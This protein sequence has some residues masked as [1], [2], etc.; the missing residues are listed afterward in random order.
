VG[1][2]AGRLSLAPIFGLSLA[3]YLNTV[4]RGEA[5]V[6]DWAGI[7]VAERSLPDNTPT[8]RVNSTQKGAAKG[9]T[10]VV[11]GQSDGTT[12]GGIAE[13]FA[14]ATNAPLGESRYRLATLSVPGVIEARDSE[15]RTST[16]V[17]KT[18][19]GQ[20]RESRSVTEIG[21]LEIAGIVRLKG[22]VW[23]TIQMTG[24]TKSV[25]GSFTVEGASLAGVPLPLPGGPSD[26][27][28]ILDPLNAALAPTGFAISLP[29][30]E[31]R[32]GQ[33]NVSPLSI[34]IINSA[35]GRQYLAPILADIRPIRE[36]IADAFIDLAKQLVETNE[37]IPDAS[38]AILAGDVALG[39][40]S[41]S[42]QLHIEMGG[43]SSFT[44][45]EAFDSP[46]GAVDFN[47]PKLGTPPKTVFT[48]GTAGTP[49]VPGTAPTTVD[50][51]FAAAPIPGSKTIPGDK[52]GV[53]MMV[54]LIGIAVAIALATRD[55]WKMRQFRREAMTT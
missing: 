12:G 34:D 2:T 28:A 44:E 45:G 5:K 43:V 53:A 3:D 46:F 48:P 10:E 40:F 17:V 32:N 26:L 16:G 36:P 31:P 27:K 39:I 9:V 19:K 14:R 37:E 35:L 21:A 41:G 51:E 20:V 22:L 30:I 15:A 7:G 33:A 4:G 52:G 38:V 1:P 6:A 49:D 54:G 24:A 42:S 50:G 13:M 55:Y 23:S 18:A 29:T 47:P 8:V 25:K 11:V